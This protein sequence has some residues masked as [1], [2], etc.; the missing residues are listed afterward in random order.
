M[1]NSYSRRISSNSSTF[2]L[3]FIPASCPFCRMLG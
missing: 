2:A 1:P 3:L